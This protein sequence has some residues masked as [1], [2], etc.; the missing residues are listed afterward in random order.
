M[1]PTP[2]PEPRAPHGS[3]LRGVQQLEGLLLWEGHRQRARE[4]AEAFAQ[5][6][7]WLSHDQ[8]ND[9]EHLYA[10]VHLADAVTALE[11]ARAR[12]GELREEYAARYAE[13]RRRLLRGTGL[14]L[15]CVLLVDVALVLLLDR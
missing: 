7:P 12:A 3:A 4:E 1:T 9:L 14:L 11:Q 8:R 6:L 10:E 13:L 15:C 5:R 2:T